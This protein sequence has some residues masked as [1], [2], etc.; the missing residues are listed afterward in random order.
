MGN[1]LK[2]AYLQS[3]KLS[4]VN[5]SLA[6]L[7]DDIDKLQKIE[8][9][10]S[11]VEY[12]KTDAIQIQ[13]CYRD[14]CLQKIDLVRELGE[15]IGYGAMMSYASALW[16]YSLVHEHE[17]VDGLGAFVPR[18]TTELSDEEIMF[19]QW[20]GVYYRNKDK[21]KEVIAEA[22]T[23]KLIAIHVHHSDDLINLHHRLFELG[24]TWQGVSCIQGCHMICESTKRVYLTIDKELKLV[25]CT[26]GRPRLDPYIY[27]MHEL[28]GID[29]SLDRILAFH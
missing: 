6:D 2:E 20:V 7:L 28:Y 17:L 1:T 26:S 18:I 29:E 8:L 9:N 4:E 3:V 16:R 22:V 24:Y 11:A 21:S 12:C 14:S 27:E 10:E 25:T 23:R 13:K 15:K 19:D 5:D